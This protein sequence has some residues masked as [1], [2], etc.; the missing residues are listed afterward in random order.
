MI[1]LQYFY[2]LASIILLLQNIIR[3]YHVAIRLQFLGR[4]KHINNK[5]SFSCS[6]KLNYIKDNYKLENWLILVY[7][8]SVGYRFFCLMHHRTLNTTVP[9]SLISIGYGEGS[10]HNCSSRS[11]NLSNIVAGFTVLIKFP[12]KRNLSSQ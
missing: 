8:M 11:T 10:S 7:I 9:M 5:N 12:E 6:L 1:C 4:L 2:S 3:L